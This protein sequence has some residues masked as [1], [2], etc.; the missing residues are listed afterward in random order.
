M[1]Y[2]ELFRILK[3]DG[4]FLIRQSGSHI[5]MGHPEKSNKIVLPF[6]ASKE[7]KKGMLVS[8]LKDANL[9]IKNK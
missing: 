7:V 8:I 5:V 1:K 2:S 4:W 3:E 9:K 6:H